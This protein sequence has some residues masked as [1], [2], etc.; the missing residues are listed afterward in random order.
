MPVARHPL[1]RSRRAPLTHRAP[2]SNLTLICCEWTN[3]S[4]CS[5]CF[6]TATFSLGV[7][8]ASMG[9]GPLLYQRPGHRVQ[10]RKLQYQQYPTCCL[11]YLSEDE[12]YKQSSSMF[13]SLSGIFSK[14]RSRFLRTDQ[15]K[16][17]MLL[18]LCDGWG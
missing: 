3:S 8:T 18:R 17:L 5:T 13:L 10:L 4:N 16:K 11:P 14:I 7:I 9:K 1:R 12:F 2:N 6:S 15:A